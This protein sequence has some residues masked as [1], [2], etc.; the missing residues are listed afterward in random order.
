MKDASEESHEIL[1]LD[2]ALTPAVLRTINEGV[3]VAD[4]HGRFVF[5]NPAATAIVGMGADDVPP[6]QWSEHYHLL[7]PGEERMFPPEQL[8][9]FRAMQGEDV[10]DCELLVINPEKK[11]RVMI[12]C[13]ARPLRND[14]GKVIG[15][16][17]FFHDVT[18]RRR[19]E[20]QLRA[21]V[22]SV[23]HDLK[24]PLTSILAFTEQLRRVLG[25]KIAPAASECLDEI[26]G[27]ALRMDQLLRDLLTHTDV[28]QKW[29]P[30]QVDLGEVMTD[31]LANLRAEI[32][33]KRA[34]VQVEPL[35]TV[36]GDRAGLT[37]VMQN[38]VGNALKFVDRS[39]TPRVQ[40][41]SRDSESAWQIF[42]RDNGIG[43]DP[44]YGQRVFDL[45][46][47][48]Q[49]RGDYPG[50]GIGLSIVKKVVEMHDGT[51]S[52]EPNAEGG[53][54]FWLQLPKRP[55]A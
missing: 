29:Q 8:P 55:A 40:I 41:G 34:A 38:L 13:N 17:I 46:R 25:P 12:N 5:W 22:H 32:E 43:I 54:T 44:K 28:G 6:E 35:P 1:S 24:T 10:D 20:G 19:V 36:A 11:K 16:V 52:F 33:A 45:F 47:R 31:V 15:G 27:G 26:R 14:F 42:V 18:D 21:F 4:E 23:S 7:V 2:P 37:Q 53:T 51:I 48:L 3:V 39:V 50:T 49:P 30:G 9:L